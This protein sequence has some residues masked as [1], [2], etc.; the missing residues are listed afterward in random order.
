MRGRPSA[1]ARPE[2]HA[3]RALLLLGVDKQCLLRLSGQREEE[4]GHDATEK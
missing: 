4:S 3:D 1:V 2:G